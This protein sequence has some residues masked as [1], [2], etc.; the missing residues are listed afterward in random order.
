MGLGERIHNDHPPGVLVA[1]ES[2]EDVLLQLLLEPGRRFRHDKGDRF[3]QTDLVLD[4]DHGA[5]AHRRV[6]EQCSLHLLGAE[7]FPLDLDGV[8]GPAPMGDEPIAVAR[9]E[10]TPDEPLAAEG[11]G[12]AVDVLPVAPSA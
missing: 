12:G 6:G 2:V 5:L 11:L 9:S 1:L 10:I 7:P 8:V 3:E 4:R